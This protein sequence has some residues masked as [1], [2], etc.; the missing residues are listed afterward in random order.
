MLISQLPCKTEV[1]NEMQTELMG[2]GGAWQV[3][4]CSPLLPPC[5]SQAALPTLPPW[6]SL[7]LRDH[8]KDGRGKK[9]EPGTLAT[10]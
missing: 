7:R 3:L 9:Q 4:C 1:V 10:L 5:T 8:A 2:L 6:V